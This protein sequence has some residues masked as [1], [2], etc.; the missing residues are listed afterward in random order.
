MSWLH[1]FKEQRLVVVGS[2]KMAVFDDTAEDKLV[3]YPH[4]VEW[5]NRV[6]TAVK[7]DRRGRPCR[8]GRAAAG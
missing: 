3:S 6:P 1:P 8:Q 4:R 2:E 5:K 7:A